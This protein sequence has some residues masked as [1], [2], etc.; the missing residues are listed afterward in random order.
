VAAATGALALA[1][2]ALA[3]EKRADSD[4]LKNV[5][6]DKRY[7][8]FKESPDPWREIARLEFGADHTFAST[9]HTLV[10]DA[11]PSQY[12][13][14]EILHRKLVWNPIREEFKDD[15]QAQRMCQ[16]AMRGPWSLV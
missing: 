6:A 8:W 1:A 11:D 9:I 2:A 13:G 3:Q 7:D 16:R 10:L 12:P 5:P 14:F 15:L 4:L